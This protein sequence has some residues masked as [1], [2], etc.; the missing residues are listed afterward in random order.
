MYYVV[1]LLEKENNKKVNF[2][3]YEPEPRVQCQCPA[4]RGAT[5]TSV[6]TSRCTVNTPTNTDSTVG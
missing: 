4:G 6:W 5:R 1:F 3:L 2:Y